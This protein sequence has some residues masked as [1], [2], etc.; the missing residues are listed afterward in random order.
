MLDAD[1]GPCDL[2]FLFFFSLPCSEY[3]S[4]E[5]YFRMYHV[6]CVYD[7]D[8]YSIVNPPTAAS[9]LSCH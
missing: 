7:F 5:M 1:K 3:V 9:Q 8:E 4:S 6:E 2:F